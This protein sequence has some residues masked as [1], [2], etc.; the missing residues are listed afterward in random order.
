MKLLKFTRYS[1]WWEYKLV[2][3]LVVGYSAI[4]INRFPI[5]KVALTL[6]IILLAIIS[7][8]IYVSVI[9]DLT[10][11]NEDAIAG[12][13]N[14]MAGISSSGRFAI[15]FISI[16]IGLYFGYKFYPDMLSIYL[17]C[18]AY[19]VFSLYSLPP[20]RLKKRGIWG[21]FC[22][23]MG[24][25]LFPALL[26][27]T[28]ITFILGGKLNLIF[29][30]ATGIWAFCYGLR[31]ILWHQFYDRDNDIKSNTNTFASKIE[32]KDFKL[33]ELTIFAIEIATLSIMIYHIFNLWLFL[34]LL[35]YLFL[36]LI[37]KFGFKYETVLIL[38]PVSAPY[39]LLMNDFY[40]VFL[41][42]SL[43]LEISLYNV[44]GWI[45]LCLHLLLFPRKT[46]LVVKDFFYFIKNYN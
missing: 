12:K 1:E 31:G 22:D 27:I 41:P 35:S 45:V 4:I 42:L 11:I 30:I 19:L 32:P 6:S 9:N 38:S 5:E 44:Y 13:N 2:P 7:G 23:A 8:A 21:V 29:L 34:S 37:R 26:M 16:I 46:V 39:Q 14:R 20:I 43:L 33:S 10:D 15:L 25:H 36:V 24:A 40:L 28:H 17:F 18:S 3:L